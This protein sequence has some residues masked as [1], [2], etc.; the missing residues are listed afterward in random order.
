[1][2]LE[3]AADQGLDDVRQ[4]VDVGLVL[5]QKGEELE[6]EATRRVRE[7]VVLGGPETEANSKIVRVVLRRDRKA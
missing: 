1:L 3:R 6:A 5:T 4:G 2:P 7:R